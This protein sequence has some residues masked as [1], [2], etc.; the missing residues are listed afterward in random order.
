[1][2]M[3]AARFGRTASTWKISISNS[4][5][6]TYF[7]FATCDLTGTGSLWCSDSLAT[8]TGSLCSGGSD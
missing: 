4:P 3:I 2:Y 1:M 8:G 6:Y 5:I 7:G